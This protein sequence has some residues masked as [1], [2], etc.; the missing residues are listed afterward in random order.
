MLVHPGWKELAHPFILQEGRK[1]DLSSPK[2][3]KRTTKPH[4]PGMWGSRQVLSVQSFCS[5]SLKSGD[6]RIYHRAQRKWSPVY[7]ITVPALPLSPIELPLLWM[8]AP[9]VIMMSNPV[10]PSSCGWWLLYDEVSDH[11]CSPELI[12]SELHSVWRHVHMNI[13]VCE[14]GCVY[15]I[16]C[17]WVSKDKLSCHPMSSTCLRWVFF[18]LFL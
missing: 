7:K 18:V 12:H 2:Q 1:P 13:R 17:T 3:Q 10:I 6:Y 5:L 16:V 15:S 14:Y 11:S 8:C 9:I 4:G